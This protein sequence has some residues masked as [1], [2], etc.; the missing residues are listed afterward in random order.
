MNIFPL[1]TPKKHLQHFSRLKSSI[2]SFTTINSSWGIFLMNF[3]TSTVKILKS[4]GLYDERKI[5][6]KFSKKYFT[7]KWI[8][9]IVTSTICHAIDFYLSWVLYLKLIIKILS[10]KPKRRFQFFSLLFHS[11][12]TENKAKGKFTKWNMQ[13]DKRRK[14]E[15]S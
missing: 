3:L 8:K 10:L 11:I 6:L 2:V 5:I 14:H 7:T 4:V 12:Q 9:T 13:G 1:Q 15:S